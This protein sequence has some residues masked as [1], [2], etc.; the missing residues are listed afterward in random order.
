MREEKDM[1]GPSCTGLRSGWFGEQS[2]AKVYRIKYWVISRI[3]RN[4]KPT[5]LPFPDTELLI[6]ELSGIKLLSAGR[7]E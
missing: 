4:G 6:T 7:S 2:A 1:Q 3:I 5:D